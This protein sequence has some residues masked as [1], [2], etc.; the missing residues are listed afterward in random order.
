M[1]QIWCF[2]NHPAV[3][4][5]YAPLVEDCL[6]RWEEEE[7][8]LTSNTKIIE[9]SF[10]EEVL[11]LTKG[12]FRR[13]IRKVAAEAAREA[14]R[15]VEVAIEKKV[16]EILA[17]TAMDIR[18]VPPLIPGCPVRMEVSISLSALSVPE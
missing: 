1:S 11:E 4:K 18:A 2:P 12:R 5:L 3:R 7:M 6:K 13:E 8:A 15:S 9:E 17:K 14:T 10:E 16:G